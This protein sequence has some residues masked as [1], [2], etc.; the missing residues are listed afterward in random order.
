MRSH[1]RFDR[2]INKVFTLTSSSSLTSATPIHIPSVSTNRQQHG[3][4][5]WDDLFSISLKA[6]DFHDNNWWICERRSLST[7]MG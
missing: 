4:V 6:N 5:P 1:V 7:P 3:F 2:N